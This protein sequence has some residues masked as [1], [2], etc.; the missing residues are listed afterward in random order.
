ME[1]ATWSQV[2]WKVVRFQWEYLI[3]NMP[4]VSRL[5]HPNV[6]F[7]HAIECGF[8]ELAIVTNN[9]TFYVN[10]LLEHVK[11]YHISD[12]PNDAVVPVDLEEYGK[13]MLE[14]GLI[15]DLD[16]FLKVMREDGEL[17]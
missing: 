13:W 11:F 14:E 1:K 4:G 8:N 12:D 16:D 10:F 2:D 7:G 3:C 17:K 9:T 5:T 6:L 15:H